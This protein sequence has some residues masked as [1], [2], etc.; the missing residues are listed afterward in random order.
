MTKA[1]RYSS[2]LATDPARFMRAPQVSQTPREIEPG[3]TT[4]TDLDAIEQRM[5]WS[6]T[7][8]T[9]EL[10]D[11][12]FLFSVRLS[13]VQEIDQIAAVH[14]HR[15]TVVDG[16]KPCLD[17]SPNGVPDAGETDRQSLK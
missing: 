11:R 8:A 1:R 15:S 7:S 9:I 17:P 2:I 5:L 14:Q 10:V 13:R 3:L 16:A 12:A 4:D 6:P